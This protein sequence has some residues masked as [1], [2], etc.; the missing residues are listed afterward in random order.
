MTRAYLVTEG[1]IDLAIL[2]R[3]LPEAV[4]T[5]VQFVAGRGLDSARSLAR[6]LLASRHRPVAL[7]V[8]ADTDEQLAVQERV[9][10]LNDYLQQGAG[11]TRFEVFA[12]VP[13]IEVLFFEDRAYVEEISQEHFS[14]RTWELAKRHPKDCLSGG[15]TIETL[16]ADLPSE[17]LH[18]IQ[19]HPLVCDLTEFLSSVTNG[20]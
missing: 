1:D 11:A 17:T 13:E 5:P 12:A 14:E 4:A 20:D 2:K 9:D 16:L 15:P 18:K 19:R 6:S 7:V 8:D 10:F 3:V